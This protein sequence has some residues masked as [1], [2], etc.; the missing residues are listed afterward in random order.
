MPLEDIKVLVSADAC[1]VAGNAI[2]LPKS[3]V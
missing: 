2:V 3:S 1:D